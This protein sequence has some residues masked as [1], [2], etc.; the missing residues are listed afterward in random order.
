MKIVSIFKPLPKTNNQLHSICE[1]ETYSFGQSEDIKLRNNLYQCFTK[2]FLK[3]FPS[4]SFAP[5]LSPITPDLLK[6]FVIQAV[7]ESPSR[8]HPSGI[9]C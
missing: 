1:S 2:S 5:L 8:L 4:F 9:F 3:S 6:S 7:G